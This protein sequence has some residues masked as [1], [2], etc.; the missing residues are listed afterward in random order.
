MRQ[1]CNQANMPFPTAHA[2]VQ[3]CFTDDLSTV[4]HQQRQIVLI[5]GMMAPLSNGGRI[6]DRLFDKEPL[7]LRHGKQE[8]TQ[9]HLILPAEWPNNHRRPITELRVDWKIFEH[10]L[11]KES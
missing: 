2:L 6:G 9:A 5:V 8:L 7:L 1:Q 3:R 4:K 10:S 11:R